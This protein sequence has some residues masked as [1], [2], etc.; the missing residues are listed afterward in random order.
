M[1]TRKTCARLLFGWLIGA[2]HA[3]GVG[4]GAVFA[5]YLIAWPFVVLLYEI[6]RLDAEIRYRRMTHRDD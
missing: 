6:T 2:A 5:A 4:E 3:C 1:T